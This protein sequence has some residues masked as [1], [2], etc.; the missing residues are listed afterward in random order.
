MEFESFHLNIWWKSSPLFSTK[1]LL[2]ELQNAVARKD[3][4][5]HPAPSRKFPTHWEFCSLMAELIHC[6]GQFLP[7]IKHLLFQPNYTSV[8]HHQNQQP[9][10]TGTELTLPC[11]LVRVTCLSLPSDFP[12]IFENPLQM[13]PS[14]ESLSGSCNTNITPKKILIPMNLIALSLIFPNAMFHNIDV[15]YLLAK[16]QEGQVFIIFK[17]YIPLHLVQCSMFIVKV[18]KFQK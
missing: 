10:P 12:S 1:L 2:T 4:S 5:N 16:I 9:T 7:F 6:P 15:S 17:L 13:L 3:L 11:C 8:L 18:Y 14:P